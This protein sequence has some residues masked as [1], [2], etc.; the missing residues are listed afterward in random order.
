M[1]P[2]A[3]R[4]RAELAVRREQLARLA[5]ARD[6]ARLVDLLRRVD[7]AIAAVEVGEWGICAVCREAIGDDRLDGV[8]PLVTIC[9]ECLSADERRS[10]ERDLEAAARVQR[11]LLPPR[12]VAHDGWEVAYLWEPRGAVSG[13]HVDL[14]L[15]AGDGGPLHLWFGDVAGKG[16][17]ASLLQSH[18]H[19]LFRALAAPDLPLAELLGRA[20][21]LFA[22]ATASASYATLVSARLHPDGRVELGNAGHPRPLLADARG[23]RPVVGGGLPLGLFGEAAYEPRELRLRP[24][25]TLLLYTDGWTE[26]AVGDEEYGVGR[27]AAAL[28]RAARLAP[29]EVV[30]ACRDD[31]HA[32]LA[33]APRGDD[34]TLLALRRAAHSLD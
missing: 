18:L 32:F 26:A 4:V 8:D 15:P 23:V 25:E 21:R 16:V 34:L 13:D 17:A 22:G 14:L 11:A 28:R 2:A 10:L 24:G 6:E 29:A 27:A 31:L 19:A 9:L 3:S 20:N 30:A 1:T 7:G 33:G 12:R 5:A